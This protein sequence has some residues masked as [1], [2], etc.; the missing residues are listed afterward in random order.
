MVRNYLVNPAILSK[1]LWLIL[2]HGSSMKQ[3][4]KYKASG[5]ISLSH[6]TPR[7]IL[8]AS[9]LMLSTM[10]AL[11][12]APKANLP[13]VI[14]DEGSNPSRPYIASGYE[15]NPSA[16]KMD[17]NCTDDP[18][19]GKT[20]W[21]VVYSASKGWGGVMWQSPANDWGNA[22]GGWDLTGAKALTFW[23]RGQRGGELVTFSYGGLVGKRFNDS[24]SGSLPNVHLTNAWRKYTI[25]VNGRNMSDIKSGFVWTVKA[26]SPPVTFYLDD[27][28]YE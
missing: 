17:R 10:A 12:G 5:G 22:P 20:C 3:P 1:N 8:T 27:I 26:K 14:Y 16:I 23:V 21:K 28:Q 6:A 24:S 15:G 25:P 2:I 4:V 19:S 11:A 7:I 9:L 13:L 18:H